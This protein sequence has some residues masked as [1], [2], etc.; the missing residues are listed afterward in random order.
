MGCDS[1][2]EWLGEE[3]TNAVQEILSDGVDPASIVDGAEKVA[4]HELLPQCNQCC[5]VMVEVL[6]HT[7]NPWLIAEGREL[8]ESIEAAAARFW[9]WLCNKIHQL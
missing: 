9:H 1:Q 3:G 5:D 2:D 8:V 7:I 6:D 4:C